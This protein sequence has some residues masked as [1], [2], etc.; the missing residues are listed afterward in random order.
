MKNWSPTQI[1]IANGLISFLIYLVA[2]TLVVALVSKVLYGSYGYGF[3][4][5][6]LFVAGYF[7]YT[8]PIKLWKLSK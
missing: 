4:L 2:L 5:L 3:P 6:R 8:R 1:K 7:A